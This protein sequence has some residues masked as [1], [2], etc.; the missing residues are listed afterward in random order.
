M[1]MSPIAVSHL[2]LAFP[3]A[4]KQDNMVDVTLLR[5]RVSQTGLSDLLQTKHA[6]FSQL[7]DI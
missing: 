2:E 3:H 5:D 4:N 1:K 7:Q 6:S